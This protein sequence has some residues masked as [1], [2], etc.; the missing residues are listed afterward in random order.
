[1]ISNDQKLRVNLPRTE[2]NV[3]IREN[4]PN[5]R[6]DKGGK[7]NI[8]PEGGSHGSYDEL[9]TIKRSRL[10][11]IYYHKSFIIRLKWAIIVKSSWGDSFLRFPMT[12]I[13]DF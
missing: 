11:Q 12:S 2:S 4:R 3:W 1:M 5:L 10:T 13:E 8:I 9:A 7:G 6:S